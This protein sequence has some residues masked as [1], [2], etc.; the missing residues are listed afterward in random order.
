[1]SHKHPLSDSF[2]ARPASM[3][4]AQQVVDLLNAFSIHTKGIAEE[5]LESVTNDWTSPS[6]SLAEDSQVVFDEGGQMLAYAAIFA[7]NAVPVTPFI[8]GCVHPD[9]ENQ[10]IG[11]YLMAWSE[12]RAHK[13]ENEVPTNARITLQTH[14]INTYNATKRL[15]E[16]FGMTLFR[17]S[18]Q[19]R[20]NLDNP[21]EDAIWPEGIT[22][23]GY[24]HPQDLEAVY[25]ADK[26]V[27]RD[28]FGYVEESFEEGFKNFK[29]HMVDGPNFDAAMWFLAMD[30]DDIAGFA[31]CR[32]H[33]WEDTDMGWVSSLGVLRP[34]RK[35]G[36]G[37]SLLLH[38][39]K[40][41][42]ERGFR[43][44]GLGVDGGNLTGAL[45]LY[46]NA[47][48]YVHRQMDRYHKVI[49]EGVELSVT[50]LQE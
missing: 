43:K 4:D 15:Y 46:E 32:K 41:N 48:M 37:T 44:V 28:H 36:L 5:T 12:K 23:R 11:S 26:E 3:D 49:R 50:E 1:M 6:F 42:Y 14:T 45:K 21:P 30:G 20:V 2:T 17:H 19:M 31:L 29:H 16:R 9:Y 40:A 47:G 8:Y 35:R 34:W 10:G 25:L 22:L 7:W 27:Y 39:F 38:A 18:F 24:Q 13:V 33:S